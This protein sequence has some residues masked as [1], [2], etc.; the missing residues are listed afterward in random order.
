MKHLYHCL[1]CLS[2]GLLVASCGDKSDPKDIAIK[3]LE[4]RNKM[5][6]KTAKE[7]ADPVTDS[8]LDQLANF[9]KMVD[10]G[11]N[12]LIS[13]AEVEI[14]GTTQFIGDTATVQAVNII[15]GKK[16]PEAVLLI[17][18]QDKKWYVHDNPYEYAPE[19][20]TAVDDEDSTNTEGTVELNA[21][22]SSAHK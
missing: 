8:T 5:D 13:E 15:G 16:N 2:L 11:V 20:V 10:K 12:D 14:V 22:D 17:K 21:I 9:T 7:Y 18:A 19:I 3:Y 6:Y 1:V 4:A